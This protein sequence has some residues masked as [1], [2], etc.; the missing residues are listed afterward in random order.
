MFCYNFLKD[1][2]LLGIVCINSATA[3]H[4]TTTNDI[5]HQSLLGSRLC[6]NNPLSN[7]FKA[8]PLLLATRKQLCR[9]IWWCPHSTH[10]LKRSASLCLLGTS[11]SRKDSCSLRFGAG[12][13]SLWASQNNACKTPIIFSHVVC[14][15]RHCACIC[16]MWLQRRLGGLVWDEPVHRLPA[17]PR[18][19]S[20]NGRRSDHLLVYR[21]WPWPCRHMRSTRPTTLRPWSDAYG[22]V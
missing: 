6:A 7:I 19:I 4:P 9:I 20:E 17:I 10:R 8:N 5:P 16:S 18:S 2:P 11:K 12:R 14:H 21:L 13:K 1:C 22:Y 3:P 15:Q